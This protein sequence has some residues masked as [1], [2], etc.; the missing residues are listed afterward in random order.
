MSPLLEIVAPTTFLTH[1][2]MEGRRYTFEMTQD[3]MDELWDVRPNVR[4]SQSAIGNIQSQD[5]FSSNGNIPEQVQNRVQMINWKE[6]TNNAYSL[7]NAEKRSQKYFPTKVSTTIHQHIDVRKG[8][9]GQL[10]EKLGFSP[11]NVL[12]SIPRISTT[13]SR[14]NSKTATIEGQTFSEQPLKSESTFHLPPIVDERKPSSLPSRSGHKLLNLAD[15][16]SYFV[17]PTPPTDRGFPTKP[18]LHRR[19]RFK[20]GRL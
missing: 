12:P 11:F 18:M 7:C 2:P 1:D 19:R 6:P 16:S 15:S 3:V 14:L 9:R 17:L 20:G 4:H 5:R 8:L 10:A 13:S